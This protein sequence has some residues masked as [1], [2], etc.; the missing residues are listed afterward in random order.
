MQANAREI[1][2]DVFFPFCEVFEIA[3]NNAK[4]ICG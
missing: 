1:E 4:M 3:T 2:H